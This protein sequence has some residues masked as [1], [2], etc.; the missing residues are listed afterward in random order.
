MTPAVAD[1]PPDPAAAPSALERSAELVRLD[2]A[3][4]AEREA[5][6]VRGKGGAPTEPSVL[7]AALVAA[8]GLG[9]A[10]VA[11][12]MAVESN[13]G[14]VMTYGPPLAFAALGLWTAFVTL[15][16]ARRWSRAEAD[17]RRRRA[18]LTPDDAP[19]GPLA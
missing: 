17:Y 12:L 3:W 13:L 4:A 6:M 16:Q 19:A 11:F 18:E 9:G 7:R 10:A 2:C 15:R 8:A 14:A 5:L 1:P